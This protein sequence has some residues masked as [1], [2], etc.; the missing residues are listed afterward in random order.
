MNIDVVI[1]GGGCG[2]LDTAFQL[3]Q[4][5]RDVVITLVNP[6]PYLL[7]RPW[8]ISLPAQ[9]RSFEALRVPLQKGAAYQLRLIT[10]TSHAW[11]LSS[12]RPG[13]ERASR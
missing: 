10:D 8:L 9:R 12:I 3:R 13:S 5:S 1:I 2:G 7:Y 11:I 4:H 6:A